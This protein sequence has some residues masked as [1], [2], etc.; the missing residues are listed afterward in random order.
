MRYR[1]LLLTALAILT[2]S[3]CNLG[4]DDDDTPVPTPEPITTLP[5]GAPEVRII[6]PQSG[7]EFVVDDPIL[8]NV[9][10]TDQVGVTSVQLFANGVVA[11]SVAS[12]A[13]SG[14]TNFSALLD[15]RPNQ[16]GELTLRV[17]AL[18]GSVQSNPAEVTVQVRRSEAQVT[19][20]SAQPNLPVI[21]P[22]DPTCRALI[23]VGLNF[24]Q[25]PSTQTQIIRVLG[26]GEILPIV[27]R[28]ADESWWQL[29]SGTTVGW[30][31]QRFITRYGSCANIPVISTA[32]N[33]PTPTP[34]ATTT[35]APTITPTPTATST[36]Q[37]PDL[38]I[39]NISGQDVVTIPEGEETVT[40]NFSVSITNRGGS[41]TRQFETSARVLPIGGEIPVGVIA[42]LNAGQSINLTFSVSFGATGTF[43]LQ[44]DA[45]TDNDVVEGDEGNNSRTF[46]V[47]VRRAGSS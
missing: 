36:P 32:T 18:R 39:S 6:S 43:A 20:T 2:L 10:A 37:M 15:Y 16:A 30:V 25:G 29:Q 5:T 40:A 33:T 11:R 26:A 47:T 17:V 38:Q 45:D 46:T 13:A 1:L 28:L 14:D 3:A 24:R 19:A 4:S 31:D 12:Q 27:G 42:G 21:D 9:Q 23:S 7:D 22:N 35:S 34:T 41:F 8:V 44:V